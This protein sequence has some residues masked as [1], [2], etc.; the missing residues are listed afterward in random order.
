MRTAEEMEYANDGR[1]AYFIN[2]AKTPPEL[3]PVENRAGDC[4]M[5][6]L[7]AVDHARLIARQSSDPRRD[8]LELCE[9]MTKLSL[10]LT[11]VQL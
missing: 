5:M 11:G 1:W 6:L 8:I 4:A 9:R 3:K 2:S 7:Y 10:A